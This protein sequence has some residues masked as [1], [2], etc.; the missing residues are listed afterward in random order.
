MK[1][2]A[3]LGLLLFLGVAV[4]PNI[5]AN[6]SIEQ[7]KVLTKQHISYLLLNLVTTKDIEVKQILREVINRIIT[8]ELETEQEVQNIVKASIGD[9]GTTYILARIKS[10]LSAGEISC[11][12][13]QFRA[14][15][16]FFVGFITSIVSDNIY[17]FI[18]KGSMVE[19]IPEAYGDGNWDFKIRGEPVN[20]TAGKIIGYFGLAGQHKLMGPNPPLEHFNL[21]G[22]G[23]IIIHGADT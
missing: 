8:N 21:K 2:F 19:Y 1:W 13:G 10:S 3:L 9:N 20:R 15:Y 7:D 6:Q 14:K 17:G 23:L 16:G 5:C 12:P 18:S 4:A 22:I 11:V